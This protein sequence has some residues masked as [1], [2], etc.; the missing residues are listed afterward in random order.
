[1]LD[2]LSVGLETKLQLK[3]HNLNPLQVCMG[4][5]NKSQTTDLLPQTSSCIDL[6]FTDQQNIKVIVV[7]IL[8]Y[9]QT[10]I[11][12]SPT[13]NLILILNIHLHMSVWFGT[14]I[15]QMLKVLKNPLSLL[16][17]K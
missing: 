14:T 16:I 17:E 12:R 13:E 4:F 9:I 6:I 7:S 2:L 10:A 11:I 3:G 8:R 15:E 1:M 5:I